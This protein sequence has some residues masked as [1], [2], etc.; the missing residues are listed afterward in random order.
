MRT[1]LLC[2]SDLHQSPV[3]HD[4]QSPTGGAAAPQWLAG[5]EREPTGL[6]LDVGQRGHRVE[7]GLQREFV[8]TLP[9]DHL[10]YHQS[11]G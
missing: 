9:F 6:V 10:K 4:L 8:I 1:V 11:G 3:Q 5:D 2:Y 7:I